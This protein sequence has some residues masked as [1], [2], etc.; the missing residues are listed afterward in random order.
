MPTNTDLT[1]VW[2]SNN[3]SGCQGINIPGEPSFPV[4]GALAPNDSAPV[5]SNIDPNEE[6]KYEIICY[7]G[8]AQSASKNAFIETV[9]GPRLTPN[10]RVIEEG[11][12]VDLHWE[13]TSGEECTLSGAGQTW[14]INAL[15]DTEGDILDIVLEATTVFTLSCPLAGDTTANVE[16]VPKGY[17]T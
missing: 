13:I 17:E 12:E 16:V 10:P 5:V 9:D 11:D 6:D 15:V 14:T 2:E 8:S 1:L 7:S 3:A 4:T